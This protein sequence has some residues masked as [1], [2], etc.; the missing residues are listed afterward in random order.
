MRELMRRLMR[1]LCNTLAARST[2]GYDEDGDL[3][4]KVG[5]V[6]FTFFKY[7]EPLVYV[8]KKTTRSTVN[9]E[10]FFP[11]TAKQAR[12]V[13]EKNRLP[14]TELVVL[15]YENKQHKKSP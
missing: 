5:F 12:R 2:W 14:T 8:G 6:R 9:G 15:D 1:R 3:T 13:W 11:M 4:L 7:R 10:H